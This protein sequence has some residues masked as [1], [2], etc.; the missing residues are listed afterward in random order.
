MKGRGGI[1]GE[2]LEVWLPEAVILSSFTMTA[3]STQSIPRS[4]KILGS[5][6]SISFDLLGEYTDVSV[7]TTAEG[8]IFKLDSTLPAY[9]NAYTR[10]TLVISR[11]ERLGSNTNVSIKHLRSLLGS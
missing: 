9:G 4:F 10:Y 7:A 11:V 5:V 6:D 1:S 2:W 3:S 8:T